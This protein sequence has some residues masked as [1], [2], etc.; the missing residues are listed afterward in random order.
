MPD[1]KNRQQMRHER[2]RMSQVR[3]ALGV[4]LDHVES[5]EVDRV[6]FLIACV[7]YMRASLDRLHAQDH[8]LHE[9]LQPFVPPEDSAN[10]AKLDALKD[11]LTK[12]EQA[13]AEFVAARHALESSGVPGQSAFAEA[14]RRF[15]DVFLNILRASQH[16]T[17]DIE[18]RE[19]GQSQW[20]YI[21]GIT[22]ESIE[23]EAT[24]YDRVSQLAPEGA[25][26]AS[27]P[28]I[29]PPAPLPDA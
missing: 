1:M 5:D 19:F 11:R 3:R 12:S 17:E 26:P 24:L 22:D 7:D 18:Q 2:T 14:G 8:R 9:C 13:L 16:S 10:Q 6:D 23:R 4:G 15:L 20:D 29:R 21:S 28:P 25:E 27:F